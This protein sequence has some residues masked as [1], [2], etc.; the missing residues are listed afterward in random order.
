MTRLLVPS[1]SEDANER[2]VEL[3]PLLLPLALFFD[4]I[5]FSLL[6]VELDEVLV[7]D[8]VVV[9]ELFWLTPFSSSS[10]PIAHASIVLGVAAFEPKSESRGVHK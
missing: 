7:V 6:P 2:F 10:F 1:V 8:A 3:L 4:T 9:D 5:T